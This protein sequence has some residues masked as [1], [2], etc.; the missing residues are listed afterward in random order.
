MH[1]FAM[2]IVYLVVQNSVEHTQTVAHV[3]C[4]DG[5]MS[6]CKDNTE[7]QV[8]AV[9]KYL[10]TTSFWTVWWLD[11][12]VIHCLTVISWVW[13]DWLWLQL[14]HLLDE[15]SAVFFDYIVNC[16][17][18]EFIIALVCSDFNVHG[19]KLMQCMSHVVWSRVVMIQLWYGH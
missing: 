11:G 19:G 4:C 10:W 6:D 15:H 1:C 13:T 16:V 7:F 9:F 12:S 8:N 2:F 18:H 5:N 3:R 14:R 17:W